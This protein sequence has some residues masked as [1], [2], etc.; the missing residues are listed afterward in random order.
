MWEHVNKQR[1]SRRSNKH[2]SMYG[3]VVIV[4]NKKKLLKLLV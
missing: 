3:K 4:W 2:G 1:K